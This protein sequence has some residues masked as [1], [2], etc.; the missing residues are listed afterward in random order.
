[1][2]PQGFIWGESIDL[3][4]YLPP[5]KITPALTRTL[6]LVLIQIARLTPRPQQF[7]PQFSDEYVE[8]KGSAGWGSIC[9]SHLT[10]AAATI[11]CRSE[12]QLFAI[13]MRSG[14]YNHTRY[15]GTLN[16]TGEEASLD[17][18]GVVLEKV[19]SCDGGE[20]IVDCTTS[21]CLVS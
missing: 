13:Q 4:E 11:I 10:L 3:S 1:M 16:C 18:C 2:G 14:N 8:V 9:R 5:P 7:H 19:D 6:Y 17:E 12:R 21:E 20:A 15:T